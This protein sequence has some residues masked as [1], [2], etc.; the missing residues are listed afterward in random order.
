MRPMLCLL[1]LL[2]PWA[3]RAEVEIT[4]DEVY[5]QVLLI[6]RETELVKRVV[7]PTAQPQVWQ[8]VQADLK[9]RHVWQKAY[10]VQMKLVAFRRRQ[11]MEGLSPV[12][13][14]PRRDY[15]PRLTWVQTQRIL[16]EIR[17]L[18]KILDIPGD[19]GAAPKVAGK[20]PVDVYNKLGEIEMQWDELAEVATDPSFTFAQALRFDEDVNALLRALNVLDNAIPPAKRPEAKPADSLAA[21]FEVLELVQRL[22]R[23]AG[24]ET[25]DFSPFRRPGEVT[26]NH[27]FNLLGLTLAELQQIKAQAGLIH[28]I[29]PPATYQENKTPADVTQFLGYVAN[30][31]RL[32]QH[33]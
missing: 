10:M 17:F 4:P 30:K 15:D 16:T 19:A 3:L 9:P 1:L 33:L 18:R 23:L 27:V 20:K 6:E 13:V 2:C 26:P 25:V 24:F 12:V 7:K 8:P 14:E 21:V 29:T 5:S 32:I 31:L 28:A 22:Q 11:G